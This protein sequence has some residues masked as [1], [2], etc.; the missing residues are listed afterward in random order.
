MTRWGAVATILAPAE[1]IL[2][3]AAF[4]LEAGAHRLYLFLDA[5]NP[6]AEAALKAHP[7][8]RVTLCDELH[9]RRLQGK[10]P[11]KHQ[12]RQTV[13]ATHAYGRAS[14]V[15][16]LIHMDVD[17]F[18][19]SEPPITQHLDALPDAIQTARTRPMER[20]AG[21][22]GTAFKRFIPPGPQREK[23]VAELYPT[24]GEHLKGGFL[25]H[26]A[27]KI[28]VRTGLPD[29]KFRIHNAFQGD[30]Q[31]PGEIRLDAVD[32][33]HCHASSWEDWIAHFRYRHASGSYRADL[34]PARARARGGM[35]MHELF[36]LIQED[37]GEAGLRV[38]FHEVCADTPA[39]RNALKARGLLGHATL[40]LAALRQRH[41][42][43]FP[44]D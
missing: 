1:D 27:G 23:L 21:G 18:L 10:R 33:A 9:W 37:S 4:H 36:S 15:D 3:F 26:L 38:F 16:W 41:F 44:P 17:E 19:I 40:N 20:L 28:F 32:L 2:N 8:V 7:K 14:D 22:D 12:S 30:T 25:S 31:N 43:D 35:S 13:N 5:E 6:V 39:L 24:F 34:G 11:E 29:I 42:P